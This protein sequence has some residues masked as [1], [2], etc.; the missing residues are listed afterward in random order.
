MER[1]Q[2]VVF[3]RGLGLRDVSAFGSWTRGTGARDPGG[4]GSLPNVQ[5]W[6]LTFDWRPGKGLLR[7]IWFRL[8]GSL[9]KE[10]GAPKTSKEFR[11][12]LNYEIPVL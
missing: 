10:A 4:G 6:D 1:R 11:L 3:A 2:W 9:V 12:I 5:E 8:R 7:G